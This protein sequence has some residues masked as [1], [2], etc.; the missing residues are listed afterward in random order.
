MV[1]VDDSTFKEV[2]NDLRDLMNWVKVWNTEE[3]QGATKKVEDEEAN[4]LTEKIQAI[5]A[6]L[7]VG[8]L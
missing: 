1:E 5:A 7:G 2:E 3:E 6:K 4:Q 8:T